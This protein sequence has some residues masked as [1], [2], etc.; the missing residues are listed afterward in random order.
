LKLVLS[1]AAE[2]HQ[3]YQMEWNVDN[4]FGDLDEFLF[5]VYE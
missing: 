2:S 1:L 5:Y 4:S 3:A